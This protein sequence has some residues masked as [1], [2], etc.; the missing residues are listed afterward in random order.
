MMPFMEDFRHINKEREQLNQ[1]GL[2]AYDFDITEDN[3]HNNK[4]IDNKAITTPKRGL[5]R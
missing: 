1:M 2:S 4:T 5:S 3:I